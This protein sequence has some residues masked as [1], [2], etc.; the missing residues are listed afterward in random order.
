[1]KRIYNDIPLQ[2][3]LYTVSGLQK[4]KII[5]TSAYPGLGSKVLFEGRYNEFL[6]TEWFDS[7]GIRVHRDRVEHSVL[8]GTGADR[9]GTIIFTICT[10]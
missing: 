5:D 2:S 7:I 6:H 4:I 8:H 10:M 9:N 3:V 1:M